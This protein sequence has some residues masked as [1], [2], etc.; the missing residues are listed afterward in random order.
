MILVEV[1][2]MGSGIYS[3]TNLKNGKMYIGMS[4]QLRKRK[5]THFWSLR[6]GHH[7]N[8]HLQNSYNKH[9][10]HNFIFNIIEEC[11]EEILSTRE[12][13][14]IEKYNSVESGYNLTYGGEGTIGYKF[15]DEQKEKISNSKLGIKKTKEQLK[16]HSK[17]MKK[18][19]ECPEYRVKM[20]KRNIGN[21]W[22][23]DRIHTEET[24]IKISKGGKGRVV[25][26]EVKEY[27][28]QLYQ[29][30]GSS[31]V[32]LTESDVIDIRLRF[33]NGER[34]CDI[35]KDYPV[36]TQSIY[37]IV[38]NRRWKHIPN[39]IEEIDEYMKVTQ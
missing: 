21:A 23:K 7:C 9:G 25:K 14:Y 35:K 16:R 5:Y 28:S 11:Q 17:A 30:E 34:Q 39:T 1:M 22:N 32:K 19:W 37:D 15:T 12:V 29:G 27:L 20:S 33:L 2:G 8:A 6:E 18:L 38:R 4:S 3:I 26:E 24:R 10:E 36:T 31:N 13:Y